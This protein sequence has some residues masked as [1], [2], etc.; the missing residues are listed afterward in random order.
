M[1]S[2]A[3]HIRIFD[4][5]PTDDLVLKRT[6]AICELSKHYQEGNTVTAI[7]QTANDIAL[8]AQLH[9]SFSVQQGAVVEAAIQKSSEAFIAEGH[10]LEML[11]C[12]MLGALQSL[13]GNGSPSGHTSPTDIFSLGLWSALS[14]QR[15]R[16]E[17]K[18]ETLR[19]ELLNAAHAHCMK[20]A[21]RSRERY[22]AADPAFT[23]PETFDAPGLEKGLEPFRK[24]ITN[25]R[26]N[27]A[28]DREE[29]DLL[30]WVMSDRSTLLDRRLSTEK[31]AALAAVTS[32]IEASLLLR[33][34]PATAHYHLA[35]RNVP[36]GNSMTFP[37]LLAAIG[38]EREALFSPFKGDRDISACPA[39]FPFLSALQTGT[40]NHENAKAKRTLEDWSARALL[41]SALSHLGSHLPS[42]AV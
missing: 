9:G 30:W 19:T 29:L 22:S 34:M 3:G 12:C 33:R 42:V 1:T 16:T 37:E 20:S 17:A 32:G 8:A 26:A 14:F 15:K 2:I 40:S 6:A 41:E 23:A 13:E 27:A 38:D 10:D 4:H 31:N 24:A 21:S 39:V 5:E 7:L 11:V 18:L 25:L 35:L 28:V 36:K